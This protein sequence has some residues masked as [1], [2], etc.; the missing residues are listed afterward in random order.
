VTAIYRIDGDVMVRAAAA[1]L[2]PYVEIAYGA[3]IDHGL[4]RLKG[5]TILISEEAH[6]GGRH[7][8][9][10]ETT[11]RLIILSPQMANLPHETAAGIISH[12]LGHAADFSYPAQWAKDS[13]GDAVLIDVSRRGG[14]VLTP[15]WIREWRDRSSD[16]V[17]RAADQIAETVLG[18]RIGYAGSCML[19]TIDKGV[20]PRPRGLR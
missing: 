14:E 3:F 7:F 8:A 9:A 1:V 4:T 6:D 19:Q 15:E 20:M 17:E 16:D 10:C 18:V 2:E 13:N 5:M 12:E 11:G